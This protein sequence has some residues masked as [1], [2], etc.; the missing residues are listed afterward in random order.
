MLSRF[1]FRAMMA[2]LLSFMLAV[3][4]AQAR[5]IDEGIEYQLVNPPVR[6]SSDQKVEV[7]ELFW[8]GCPH[9]YSFEPKLNAWKKKQGDNIHFVR[10][11]AIFGNRP[12]W[13]LHAR[14]YYTAELL[15]VLD[16]VHGPLFDAIQKDR[17]RMPSQAQLAEFFAQHGVDRKTFNDTMHSFGVQMMIN[18]AKDLTQRYGIDGV[19]TLIIGGRYRTH[20][21]LTNGQAGMLKVTDHLIE[22][23]VK[24]AR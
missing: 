17:R 24:S 14:A 9:C 20:A 13:E 5:D 8:Y 21:S 2:G 18:R 19:P 3:P 16:K 4:L 15:G 6:P 7:V 10:I 11:P 12:T 1:C 23:A 22:K